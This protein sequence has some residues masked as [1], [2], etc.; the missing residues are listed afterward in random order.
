MT[1]DE[2]GRD[3]GYTSDDGCILRHGRVPFHREDDA[4]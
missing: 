4:L 2:Y 3:S 1:A